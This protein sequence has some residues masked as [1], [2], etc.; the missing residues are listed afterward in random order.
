MRLQATVKVRNYE[1]IHARKSKGLSQKGLSEKVGV[2]HT[3]VMNLEK[4]DYSEPKNRNAL[5]DQAV[6][7]A[8]FLEIPVD[9]VLPESCIGSKLETDL[10]SIRDI[11]VQRL[12][13]AMQHAK[14]IT[15]PAQDLES[16]EISEELH[17]AVSSLS[18]REQEILNRRWELNGHNKST[19]AEIGEDLKLSK[20][21]VRQIEVRVL[22]HLRDLW[23][24]EKREMRSER[25][26]KRWREEIKR[27]SH[28]EMAR[29]YRFA[30]EG[31]IVFQP[32]NGLYNLFLERFES[33]GGMTPEI[34]KKIGW[35]GRNDGEG[36]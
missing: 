29:L 28:R 8:I 21:R 18:E 30:P 3:T 22:R 17:D 35:K 33:L 11:S 12:E 20:E 4:L 16:K 19:Y 15:S 13:D 26:I 34:S 7:I 27:M 23:A 6:K 36:V 31:H 14:K 5:L 9:D 24:E 10:V 25:E 32:E 1:M 2:P